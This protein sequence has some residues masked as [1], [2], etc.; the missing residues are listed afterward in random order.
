MKSEPAAQEKRKQGRHH[1]CLL[2]VPRFPLKS[3]LVTSPLHIHT[4]S[5]S[6]RHILKKCYSSIEDLQGL[7]DE[8]ADRMNLEL[9]PQPRELEV[10]C[11][12][13]CRSWLQN[14]EGECRTG[15]YRGWI[16]R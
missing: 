12:S 16:L 11:K 7:T 8:D 3:S 1:T 15:A 13:S 4:L 2:H 10:T 9:D 5:L 6:E 14:S